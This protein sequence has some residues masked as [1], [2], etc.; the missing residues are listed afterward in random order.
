MPRIAR[1][2]APGFPHHVTQR[3]NFG[4]VVFGTD[5]DRQRY[6]E[7]LIEYAEKH[8]TR[9]WAWC[10]MSNHVHFIAVPSKPDSL[11]RTFN[12]THMRF[13]NYINRRM[14]RAGHVW[15]SRF[16]SC[17]LDDAHL[18]HALRYVERNPVRARIVRKAWRYEWSSAR[19]H[20]E[21]KTDPLL[22]D[23]C[24]LVETVKD[25]RKYLSAADDV[26][27]MEE[28]SKATRTGRPFGSARFVKRMEALL[29][30][31]LKALPVGRPR[32]E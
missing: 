25:W 2:V 31:A 3:G 10:L 4:A 12:S 8:G 21:G 1:A 24:P 5:R 13:S 32:K 23:D 28:L 17:A 16:Y 9:F 27:V 11:A 26:E 14:K 7:W 15:Q 6:I 30:R 22:S 29:G 20:V 19:A 18:F